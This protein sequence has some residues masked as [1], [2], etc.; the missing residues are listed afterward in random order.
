MQNP[1][2]F[3]QCEPSEEH[4]IITKKNLKILV[5]EKNYPAFFL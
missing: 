4:K 2:D 3:W 5:L 1:L